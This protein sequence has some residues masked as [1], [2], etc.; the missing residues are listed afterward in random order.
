MFLEVVDIHIRPGEQAAFEAA[1]GNA[2]ATI[3][4][5]AKGVIDY[6]L[7]KGVESPERYILQVNWENVEDHTVTYF[8]SAERQVW[9]A[10]VV[11]FFAQKPAMEHFTQVVAS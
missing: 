11:P 1:L 9:L 5:K 10:A 3:T 6:K 8:N 4:A 7:H 2:L